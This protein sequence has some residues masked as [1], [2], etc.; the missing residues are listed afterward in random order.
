MDSYRGNE[1]GI[2]HHAR[3]ALAFLPKTDTTWLSMTAIVWGDAHGFAGDMKAAHE[4]RTEALKVCQEA[5]DLYFIMLAS[6][7]VAITVREQGRLHET[8]AICSQQ[9]QLARDCGLAQTRLMGLFLA[10][11]GEV[12]AEFG[13]LEGAVR[14]AQQGIALIT[15]GIDMSMV[16]WSHLC[17]ARI[18]FSKGDLAG[19]DAAIRKMEN[20]ARQF[21]VPPWITGQMAA[22]QA[23]LWLVEGKLEAAAQWAR[24]RQQVVTG[25]HQPAHDTGYFSLIEQIMLARVLLAQERLDEATRLL[26]ELLATATA[27]DR[28]TRA[29]EILNLQALALHAEGETVRAMAALERSLALAE[30]Q[31]F[32][33]MY[34]DE[35]RQMAILLYDALTR[36]I[37]PDYV[38]RLLATFS[39]IE[40]EQP[41][42]SESQPPDS[43]LIEPLSEREIEVLRLVADG[44]TNQQIAGQLFL[45]QHT[46]KVHVRNI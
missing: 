33:Q 23:R 36:G 41:A 2:I 4:A 21:F 26:Q 27:D 19:A 40:P 29:I 30:P 45:S 5:G 8:L 1:P 16:G 15:G 39:G 44:L 22:M 32:M 37:A 17:L 7:K 35:G 12:L 6:M 24:D 46:V 31:G 38:R 42:P 43:M 9:V 11:R 34:V 18:L 14:E 10:I 13:D 28:T 25:T 20:I 3:Q